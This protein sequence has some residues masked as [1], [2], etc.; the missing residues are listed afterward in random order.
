MTD[1]VPIAH[2]INEPTTIQE[3]SRDAGS[4]AG[5]FQSRIL[6][7]AQKWQENQIKENL[8]HKEI[9]INDDELD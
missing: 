9:N 5:R 4:N 8:L 1:A 6:D 7:C 2:N 3:H